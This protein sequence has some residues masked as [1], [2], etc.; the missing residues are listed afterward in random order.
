M[1]TPIRGSIGSTCRMS[2]QSGSS[3]TTRAS[4]ASASTR[5]GQN[6]I[7]RSLSRRSRR[8]RRTCRERRTIPRSHSVS[9]ASRL[10][11]GSAVAR[12][13]AFSYRPDQ[14]DRYR[15]PD[16]RPARSPARPWRRPGA[17]RPLRRPQRRS[18]EA[19]SR[20]RTRPVA[21]GA[22]AAHTPAGAAAAATSG[23]L[24]IGGSAECQ[25]DAVDGSHNQQDEVERGHVSAG[26]ARSSGPWPH[27]RLT[28]RGSRAIVSYPAAIP[29]RA[30]SA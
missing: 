13:S 6:S 24:S 21:R 25:V 1:A 10:S 11:R 28:S 7:T 22:V 16:R 2:R 29:S 3:P 5:E 14:R 8:P 20:A 4:I 30:P 15:A 23:F 9:C 27:R 19:S 26:D 12:D 18:D 17:H